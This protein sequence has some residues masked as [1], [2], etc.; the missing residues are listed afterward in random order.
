MVLLVRYKLTKVALF[1]SFQTFESQSSTPKSLPETKIGLFG[2]VPVEVPITSLISSDF[3]K[4][5]FHRSSQLLDTSNRVLCSPCRSE[6][7]ST[8]TSLP[9]DEMNYTRAR[10]GEPILATHTSRVRAQAQVAAGDEDARQRKAWLASTH[11]RVST[12]HVDRPAT[13]SRKDPF[14]AD[15]LVPVGHS[16]STAQISSPPTWARDPGRPYRA[17]WR[18]AYETGPFLLLFFLY[19]FFSF[20][21]THPA[22]GVQKC[23]GSD[24]SSS[25]PPQ[26]PNL[27]SRGR[28]FHPQDSRGDLAT[29]LLFS[30]LSVA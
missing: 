11:A 2:P 26:D 4:T 24:S 12:R 29:T 13:Q 14:H 1:T 3:S 22:P 18:A 8:S 19:L 5:F 27:D 20:A 9:S 7:T 21:V 16:N 6:K 30:S 17:G 28:G 23:S 25:P 15:H 10:H